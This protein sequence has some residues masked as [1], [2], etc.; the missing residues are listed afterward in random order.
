MT[1]TTVK[2]S[3]DDYHR[4]MAIEYTESSLEKDLEVKRKVY[5]EAGIPEYWVVN[6]KAMQLA[7][8]K[9]K[10]SS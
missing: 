7:N 3:L 8:A 2:W 5:A 4:M 9:S 1:V 10:Q 6:L